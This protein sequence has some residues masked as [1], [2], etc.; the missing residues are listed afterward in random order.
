MCDICDA[1][2]LGVGAGGFPSLPPHSPP[3]GLTAGH[4]RRSRCGGSGPEAA[5]GRWKDAAA[6][7]TAQESLVTTA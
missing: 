1:A 4:G 6:A 7:L 2:A 3:D 5:F